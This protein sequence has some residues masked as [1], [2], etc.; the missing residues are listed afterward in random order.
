[1]WLTV[2]GRYRSADVLRRVPMLTC[3]CH[4]TAGINVFAQGRCGGT[5]TSCSTDA[6]CGGGTCQ[7]AQKVCS[8]DGSTACTG[9]GSE[10]GAGY[11]LFQGS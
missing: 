5:T 4:P 9:F 10:C 6:E 7:F 11:C 3:L 2:R 8:N 1:M